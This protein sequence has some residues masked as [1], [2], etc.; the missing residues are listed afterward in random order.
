MGYTGRLV[1]WLTLGRIE[2][3]ATGGDRPTIRWSQPEM[4]LWWDGILLDAREDWNE[5]WAIVDGAGYFDFQE[6]SGG[7][8]YFWTLFRVLLKGLWTLRLY[9]VTDD[10]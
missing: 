3:K 7:R 9:N 8:L 4:V 10:P 2:T 5:D 1:V 6:V